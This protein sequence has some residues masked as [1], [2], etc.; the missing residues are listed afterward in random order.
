M[1]GPHPDVTAKGIGARLARKEDARFL[2][3]RG[4]FVADIRLPDMLDVAFV[5]SPMAHARITGIEKPEGCES[6]VYSMA[7]MVGVKPIVAA[8][9]LPGFQ[10]SEQYPLARDKVRFVGEMVAM[11]VAP[12]R[13][14]AEDLA[15]CVFVDYEELPVVA[16]MHEAADGRAAAKLHDHWDSNVFLETQVDA[17]E[18][19]ADDVISVSRKLST[20]RQCQVPLEGRGVV[21]HWDHRLDRLEMTSSAQMPH[22]NRTG[23]AECLG[24]DEGQVRVVS[25]DVG[26]GFGYKG[27]LL[28]EE[29]C[30]AWLAMKLDRPIRWIEDRGE[31]LSANANCR[32]HAY[33]IT[34]HVE[35][36]GRLAGIECDAIVDSGAYSS[37]PFSAC[38]EAAQVGS[39]L[40]GPYKMDRYSCHTRSAATNKPPILPYRGVARTGV[41]F[42]L[43]V[44]LD[45]AARQLGI[46]PYELRERSLVR[47]EDM[48][49]TNITNKLFDSGDYLESMQRAVAALDWQ[50]WRARQADAQ[51][52]KRIGLGLA[53]F[54]EQGAHGT[55]VYHGWGIPMVP[56]YE[57]CN[58]RMTPDG[59]LEMQIGAHSHGQSMETTL[60]QVAHTVLGIDP[61]HVRLVHG[62]TASS[63]YSTGTW[64]SR[65]AVMSGG[66]VASACE[67]MAERLRRLT[68]HLL[69]VDAERLHFD[70]GRV[71]SGDGDR[72]M[73]FA[74]L[75]YTWYRAPQLLPDDVDPA[76]L[77]LV[78]GYKMKPDMGTFSYATH[79]CVAEVDTATGAVRLLDYAICE[80]GGVLLNPMVVEGQLLGGLAQ[81]IGTA[82]YE[83]MPFDG[84]GQP[85]ASTLAD[86]MLPGA[87][88]IPDPKIDHMETP[89]PFSRF[90][91]K[92]IGEGGAI[93]PPA[94]IANAVNDALA[95]LGAEI[96]SVPISPE[97]V[98]AALRE[99][100]HESH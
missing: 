82:L 92:G 70:G 5:R 27:I 50:G 19:L 54:C 59:I 6:L 1:T 76:G 4:Q 42:A 26:G 73:S 80:D 30:C 34:V 74:E 66:A 81:G 94:A 56:G 91:Q 65:C 95:G 8:S 67:A 62:D 83:E 18:S 37:Y 98:I 48:P 93:A 51:G 75:A 49:Y 7:D 100:G 45:A 14:R 21:C 88:E 97:R 89:S 25:P 28:P 20:S 71:V 32:E 87:G 46:E 35:R 22:L 53:T 63:P 77:G 24:L 12:S 33:D 60:A 43:E 58:L 15:E 16:D 39:I 17:G 23:L 99:A 13:A 69:E 52:S 68:A 84:E 44:A 85:L 41:C 10:T 29:I 86:Y 3:G 64:G 72:A 31:H 36:S 78:A 79:A 2:S 40:P 55:S 96:H 38:L 90:G 57:Q 11:C 47:A 9:K 61:A